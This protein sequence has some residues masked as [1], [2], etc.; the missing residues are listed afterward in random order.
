V[1]AGKDPKVNSNTRAA[2]RP[3][4][5]PWWRRDLSS[6]TSFEAT[7]VCVEAAAVD[8]LHEF[9]KH[10]RAAAPSCGDRTRVELV[11]AKRLLPLT[12]LHS[13]KG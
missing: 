12:T 10:A 2:W 4:Y 6:R 1:S 8:G 5:A 9:A 13:R 3:R 11:P 7:A